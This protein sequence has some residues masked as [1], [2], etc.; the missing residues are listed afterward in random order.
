MLMLG[1]AALAQG[2]GGPPPMPEKHR[3][4]F[5]LIGDVMT[6]DRL[7]GAGKL[8]LDASEKKPLRAL[9]VSLAA[10]KNVGSAEAG[11]LAQKLKSTLSV[12]HR[13]QL[14]AGAQ[15]MGG[16]GGMP[17]PPG[18]PGGGG[19]GGPGGPPPGGGGPG[20]PP[21][22]GPGG[23]PGGGLFEALSSGKPF[24]PFGPSDPVAGR[25]VKSLIARLGK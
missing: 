14:A 24:N 25:A 6:L 22:G 21:P 19:P 10:R 20:G 17:P 12:A 13:K 4:L 2:P 1:R 23:P 9:L 15:S 16:P 3:P 8:K 18:G 5:S 11:W 7:T